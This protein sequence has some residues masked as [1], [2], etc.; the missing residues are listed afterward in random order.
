M[1]KL[2]FK[3]SNRNRIYGR[4]IKEK[5]KLPPRHSIEAHSL[6]K[7]F[8]QKGPLKMIGSRPRGGDEIKSNR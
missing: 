6:L 2:P 8:V 5:V 4:I 1:A 3:H 7:G